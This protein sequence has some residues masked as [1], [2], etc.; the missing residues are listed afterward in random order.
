LTT[1]T[2]GYFQDLIQ[3]FQLSNPHLI[4]DLIRLG[5]WSQDTRDH[6]IGNNGSVQELKGLPDEYKELYRTVWEIKQTDL[7]EMAADRG[8]YIDQSQSMSLYVQSPSCAK[9]STAHFK[10]WRAVSL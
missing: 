6:I 3:Y 1:A 2:S 9:M 8:P 5:L 7:I 4:K 10:A